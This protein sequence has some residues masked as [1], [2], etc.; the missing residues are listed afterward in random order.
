MLHAS[1][2]DGILARIIDLDRAFA[3][4][5]YQQAGSLTFAASDPICRWNEGTWTLETDGAETSMRR[6]GGVPAFSAP[7]DTLSMLLF[8]QISASE[9]W[10]MGRLETADPAALPTADRLLCTQ[11]RPFCA[12]HF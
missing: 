6:G 10:R 4:R 3:G 9:A 7:I 8:G 2:R 5:G 12:D 11:Y 1:S